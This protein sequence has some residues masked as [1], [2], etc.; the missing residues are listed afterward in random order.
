MPLVKGVDYPKGNRNSAPADFADRAYFFLVNQV[1]K[2]VD[3]RY[4]ASKILTPD[5]E[6]SNIPL[7]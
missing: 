3:L 6:L 1:N 4:R 2:F 7:L 5:G